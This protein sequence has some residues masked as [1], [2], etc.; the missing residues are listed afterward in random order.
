MLYSLSAHFSFADAYVDVDFEE[1][2]GD[3]NMQ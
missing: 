3:T 1:N 2:I